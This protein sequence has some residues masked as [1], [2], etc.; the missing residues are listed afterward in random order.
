MA[1]QRLPVQVNQFIGGLNTEANPLSFPENSSYDELNIS[2]NTD[3]SRSRRAGFAFEDGSTELSTGF[4]KGSERVGRSQF[5]WDNPG[6]INNKQLMVVQIGDYVGIHDM[7]VEPLSDGLIYSTNVNGEYSSNTFSY[8]VVDGLLIMVT[9]EKRPYV[10]S[11]EDGAVT[12]ARETLL[13]RDFFGVEAEDIS[14][15]RILTEAQNVGFRPEA[16]N[17]PSTHNYNLRNQTYAYPRAAKTGVE[18]LLDPITTFSTFSGGLYPS[19]SDSVIPFLYPDTEASNKTLDVYDAKN[20]YSN[21]LGTTYAP[22]GFFI[23]DALARGPSRLEQVA[24]LMAEH[25]GLAVQVPW[26]PTD[27][28]PDGPTTIEQYAGRVWYGGFNGSI[29]G[30][31]SKSPR[32]SSYLLFSRVIE[33]PSQIALCYQDADPT[34]AED[35][36]IVDSDGGF[37]K[38]DGAYNIK[39]L[40][41]NENSLF[42]IAEN[43]IWRVV[44]TDND[45]FRATGYSV[46]KLSEEGCVSSGSIVKDRSNIFYWG[47]ND[48]FVITRNEYGDW[49]VENLSEKTISSLYRSISKED[50]LTVSSVY[51][52][53]NYSIR[54]L[55]GN[56]ISKNTETSE[57]I[58]NT[59]FGAFTKYSISGSAVVS[60]PATVAYASELEVDNTNIVTSQSQNVTANS[61]D[62]TLPYSS[63]VRG[64]PFT[65]YCVIID[66]TNLT[67][68]F[69]SYKDGV[70]LDWGTTDS[71]AWL[72]TGP[73]TAGDARLRKD[74]P[75][76]TTYFNIIEDSSCGISAIWDWTTSRDGG[77]WSG[78]REAYRVTRS[79]TGDSLLTTRNRI[80]G[81]GTAVSF[82]FNSGSGKPFTLYGWDFNLQANKEE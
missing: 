45:V 70:I 51:D 17:S 39:K 81:S 36:E 34:S 21:P 52:V 5:V 20:H 26:V 10:F 38:V 2:L 71:P 9:G 58:L 82:A 4:T 23:I 63:S 29:E 73:I 37:L 80:R 76:L 30:G 77:R 19:N 72:I 65:I 3:G 46:T 66:D 27:T 35:A 69:G 55:Y 49:L 68:S 61:V 11:Y 75:Y 54:W 43:G 53:F 78:L 60:G 22:K 7:D 50:R 6:G 42:V 74:V 57:L 32:M 64:S 48:I 47:D 56:D 59:K 14:D 13:I 15:G 8:A 1:R 24:D 41:N 44:G 16:A 33:E 62:V 40:V 12:S 67:Y 79:A 28:T 31:D 25:P 18:T